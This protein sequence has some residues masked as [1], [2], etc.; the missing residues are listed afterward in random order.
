MPE[1]TQDE[2]N[3]LERARAIARY[4]SIRDAFVAVFGPPGQPNPPAALVLSYIDRFCH[5]SAL[6]I[7]TDKNDATDIPKTFRNIGRREV[8]TAIHDMLSWRESDHANSS[9]ST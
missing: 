6:D 8:A 1:T 5:R 9:G 3:A 2:D 4:R 7:A